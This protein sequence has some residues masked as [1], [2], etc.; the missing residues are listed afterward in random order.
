MNS[1]DPQINKAMNGNEQKNLWMEGRGLDGEEKIN[2]ANKGE[3]K[4][5]KVR[6]L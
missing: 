2:K 5:V 4:K 3:T 1:N 6:P